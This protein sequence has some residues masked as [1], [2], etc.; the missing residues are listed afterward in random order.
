[1]GE[2]KENNHVQFEFKA[3]LEPV[4]AAQIKY[5]KGNLT[6]ADVQFIWENNEGKPVTE[7]G[8]FNVNSIIL[9]EVLRKHAGQNIVIKVKQ[10][11]FKTEFFSLVVEF[12]G[13]MCQFSL[14][15]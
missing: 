12:P 3:P 15:G 2:K 11:H 4:Q 1:M 5:R 9:V 8:Y 14:A 13:M 6:G 7:T 10:Y